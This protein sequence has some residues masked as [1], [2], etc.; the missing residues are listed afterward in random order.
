MNY[1]AKDITSSGITVDNYMGFGTFYNLLMTSSG[2]VTLAGNVVIAPTVVSGQQASFSVRWKANLV[3]ST[4]SVVICG[5]TI[6]QDICNQVG[7]FDCFYDGTTWSVIYTPDGVEQPQNA[8]DAALVAVPVS[9]TLILVAG[10]DAQYQRL[11]GSPT[12]LAAAY[13]VTAAT[14]G[15]KKNTRFFVEIGGSVTTGSNT[16]TVFGC[17]IPTYFALNGGVMVI[18]TFDGT[19]WRGVM[20]SVNNIAALAEISALSI[21]ANATNASATPT[22]VQIGTNGYVLK[23]KGNALIAGLIE[24]ENLDPTLG[25]VQIAKVS[26]SSA[27]ILAGN[28]T[29]KVAVVSPGVGKFIDVLAVFSR[30][31]YRTTPYATNTVLA[32]GNVG[33][34]FAI[35]SDAATLVS[36]ASRTVTWD[37]AVNISGSTSNTQMLANTDL[38]LYV[39]GGDPTAGDSDIIVYIAYMIVSQ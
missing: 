30:I 26:M 18:A 4:F 21:V 3:L 29:K 31:A 39:Q 12:T 19:V 14:S 7:Q 27:E 10:K 35:K 38:E 34:G 8:Q 24:S 36:T 2:T 9:G 15:V 25:F 16:Y 23:R 28:T 11:V 32:I 1:I 20:T 17:V 37:S 13:N 6:N 33:A 5:V 22:A